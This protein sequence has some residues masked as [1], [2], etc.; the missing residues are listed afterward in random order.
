MAFAT[1]SSVS[2]GQNA[3]ITAVKDDVKSAADATASWVSGAAD[4]IANATSP[5]VE[6]TG[7]WVSGALDTVR[8]DT[9]EAANAT[10]SWIGDAAASAKEETDP[11]MDYAGSKLH[12]AKE[13]IGSA[14]DEF[15]SIV[16]DDDDLS[17][18]SGSADGSNRTASFAPSSMTLSTVIGAFATCALVANAL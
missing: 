8:N 7:D 2:L 9:E 1:L 14:A 5:S 12:D 10:G 13:A 4:T 11:A 16:E 18:L 6:A 17:S 3:S 15:P